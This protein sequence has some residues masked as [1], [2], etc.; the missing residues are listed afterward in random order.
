ARFRNRLATA[1]GG[2]RLARMRR[3][4]KEMNVFGR[5]HERL[6]YFLAL[7]IFNVFP[8]PQQSG[9]L[10]SFWFAGDLAD[11]GWNILVFPEGQT[12]V[13][14][15][16]LAFRSG[17]GLLAKQLNIPVVPM[18]LAGSLYDMKVE[19]RILA[20]PGH[21]KVVIGQPVRF[22]ADQ[23]ANEITRELERRVREL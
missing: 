5:L 14:G 18:R 22:S 21:V 19:H 11:R 7:S 15:N 16:M 4:P 1:M 6:D 12:T 8:L 10:K 9:F 20:R 23:D 2:E 3:P 17:I 13:D